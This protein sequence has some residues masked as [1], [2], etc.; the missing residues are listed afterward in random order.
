MEKRP[1]RDEIRA[2]LTGPI[3]SI[4][5][6]FLRDGSIDYA[7]LCQQIDFTIAAGGKTV[8][9]TAGDS[10][11]IILSDQEIA[12]V[13]KATIEHCAGRAM[14]VVAARTY[15]TPQSVEFAKFARDAGADVYMVLPP[16]W[17]N[18]STPETLTEHYSTIA[19][20]LPVMLVTNVFLPRGVEFGLSTLR[21]CLERVENIVAIKDDFCGQFGR[22]MALLVHDRWAVFTVLKQNHLD[23]HPYG[24][25]G[26]LSLL[27]GVRPDLSRRYWQ[28]F[29]AGDL[30]SARRVISDYEMPLLDYLV[31]L[32]GSWDAGAHGMLELFGLSARWRRKP[33]HSLSDAEMEQLKAKLQALK[34]M[35]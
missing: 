32:P 34:M 3:W 33:Y 29:Q 18:S 25:D 2:A 5:T 17:G 12:D 24:C 20:H 26:Y 14:V 21:L 19:E 15:G 4:Y 11:Y 1:S 6:P 35:T 23:V 30:A 10:H 9:L 7:G 27:V 13:T 22:K 8:L 28:A 31:A 16:D